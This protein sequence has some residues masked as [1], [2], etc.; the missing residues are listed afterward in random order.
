MGEFALPGLMSG[1]SLG[2]PVLGG[3][4]YG[5]KTWLGRLMVA[6]LLAMV[7]VLSSCASGPP[8]MSGSTQDCRVV[9][10]PDGSVR[11]VMCR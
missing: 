6:R 3:L 1:L 2:S 8:G 11:Q 9:T 10:N 5:L 7:L 4:L